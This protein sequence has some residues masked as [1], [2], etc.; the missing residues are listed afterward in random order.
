MDDDLD[1]MD[2]EALITEALPGL[3]GNSPNCFRFRREVASNRPFEIVF[4]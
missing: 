4:Y 1:R 3:H 2:G